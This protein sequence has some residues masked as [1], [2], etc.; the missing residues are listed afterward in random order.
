MLR[1]SVLSILHTHTHTLTRTRS[2]TSSSWPPRHRC[3]PGG[4]GDST[5]AFTGMAEAFSAND[6][7][8]TVY[9]VDPRGT[10]HSSLLTCDPQPGTLWNPNNLSSIQPWTDCIQQ[11]MANYGQVSCALIVVYTT[12]ACSFRCGR[13]VFRNFVLGYYTSMYSFKGIARDKQH[14]T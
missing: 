1:S 5:T 7:S 14:V 12:H 6:P 8:V 13:V 4:P 11:L 2:Y 10:G 9:L 3:V